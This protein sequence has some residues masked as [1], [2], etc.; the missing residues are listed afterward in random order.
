MHSYIKESVNICWRIYRHLISNLLKTKYIIYLFLIPHHITAISLLPIT[1]NGATIIG[2]RPWHLPFS[3]LYSRSNDHSIWSLHF[4]SFFLTCYFSFCVSLLHLELNLS[5]FMGSAKNCR[6]GVLPS[7]PAS[8]CSPS[9]YSFFPHTYIMFSIFQE[10]SLCAFIS[11]H[12]YFLL[13][14]LWIGL[15]Y[16]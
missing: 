10:K 14:L 11:P 12:I 6:I 15:C 13:I 2:S 5:V 4:L 9:H 16:L 1:V 7:S 8:P 3:N